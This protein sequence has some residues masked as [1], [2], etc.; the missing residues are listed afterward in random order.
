MKP[1]NVF[2]KNI[3]LLWTS[4]HD[5]KLKH[6]IFKEQLTQKMKNYWSTYPHAQ[7]FGSTNISGASQQNGSVLS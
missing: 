7:F 1:F 4:L 3:N 2:E 5:S 6:S